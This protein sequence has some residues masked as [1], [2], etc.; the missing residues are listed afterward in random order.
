MNHDQ[1]KVTL[2][3]VLRNIKSYS[4]VSPQNYNVNTK[5]KLIL[6]DD[7]MNKMGTGC[8]LI[9]CITNVRMIYFCRPTSRRLISLIT[10]PYWAKVVAF[11]CNINEIYNYIAVVTTK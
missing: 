3:V 7:D 9:K 10:K 4:I 2:N 11:L 6:H 1:F 8:T 5:I